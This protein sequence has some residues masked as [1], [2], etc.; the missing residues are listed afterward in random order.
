MNFKRIKPIMV[1]SQAHT[2]K[3]PSLYRA[4]ISGNEYEY[5]ICEMKI[6]AAYRKANAP[7][8]N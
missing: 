1:V 8:Q 6:M 7:K 3:K 4:C 2:L 5:W